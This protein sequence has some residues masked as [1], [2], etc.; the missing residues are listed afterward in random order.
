MI[1]TCITLFDFGYLLTLDVQVGGNN[2]ETYAVVNIS[3]AGVL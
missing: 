3:L 2:D 1:F